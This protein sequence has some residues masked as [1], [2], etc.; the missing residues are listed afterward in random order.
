M[1]QRARLQAA[2]QRN[3]QLESELA[4]LKRYSRNKLFR[5][6]MGDFGFAARQSIVRLRAMQAEFDSEVAVITKML[7]LTPKE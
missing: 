1:G 2:E 3:V 5:G 4:D 7:N 6:A